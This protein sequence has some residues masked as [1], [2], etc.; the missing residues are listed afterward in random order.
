MSLYILI[1]S[2]SYQM[3]YQQMFKIIGQF[4]IFYSQL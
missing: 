4:K 2:L 1:K 3:Y